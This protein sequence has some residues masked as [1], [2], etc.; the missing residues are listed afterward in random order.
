MNKSMLHNFNIAS[1]CGFPKTI[2][3]MFSFSSSGS[4][5]LE[6]KRRKAL[7]M[8]SFIPEKSTQFSTVLT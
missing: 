2:S 7:L 6:L 5:M 4:G 8:E 1:S 3:R